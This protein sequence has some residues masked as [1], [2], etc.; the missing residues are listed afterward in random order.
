MKSYRFVLFAVG[1]IIFL[2]LSLSAQ[3]G[4]EDKGKGKKGPPFELG[5]VLP[6]FIRDEL[7]LTD[8]QQK[9]IAELEKL[10]RAKLLKILTEEQQKRIQGMAGK[11]PKGPEGKD[12]G[13]KAP[14][15]EKDKENP[16]ERPALSTDPPTANLVKNPVFARGSARP[17]VPDHYTLE[18]DVEWVPA[19]GKYEFAHR[20]IALHSGKDLNRDGSRSGSVSQDVIAFTPGRGKWFRFSCRG[21]AES[22]FAVEKD[23]L[24]M[25][26]DYFSK[27]GPL[28]G[29]TRK[30]YPQIEKDRIDLAENGKR[31]Q[32]GGS[33]WKTYQH[34]FMLPF[35][36]IDR[37]RLTVVFR[38]GAAVTDKQA[39]FFVS[40]FSLI[41]IPDP[42]ER[43]RPVQSAKGKLVAPDDL[44]SL[45]GRW[46]YRPEKPGDKTVPANLVIDHR[47]A[48]QLFYLDHQLSNPF[49]EN[50]SSWLLK[51]YL[52][53][54]GN[55]VAQD[56]FVPD[57]IVIRFE[58]KTMI[59]QTK[60]L[61]NHPTAV[62]PALAGSGDRNPNYI[63]EQS[64]TFYLPLEPKHNPNAKA[65]DKTNSNRALPMGPIG[66]ALNGVVFFN[67]F[68]ADIQD[69]TDLMDRCCGHP[70]P[71]NQY[72]Y[73]KYPVCV[74]SPFIDE[75]NDHS[76]LIGFALDGF[77]VYGPYE[78]KG[79]MAKDA[80]DQ[81]LNDFNVH[82]DDVH[83]WH[84][85]VTP[86]RY[87]Y[88]IGGYWG[89][90][91]ARNGLKKGGK[92]K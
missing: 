71:R 10:V 74:K 53:R 76:P 35:A 6:P 15:E 73:H 45:G 4:G 86:G 63:Q 72:H 90:V 40:E 46:Y 62:F 12:K 30:L 60:N 38:H 21:L 68:D 8:D 39:Q 49:A 92:K 59:V 5:K 77:P 29:V 47:N 2:S 79:Q 83:G 33:V 56:R 7:D 81:P 11:G 80:R 36:E 34:D 70:S 28:D 19:G 48:D 75:G 37:L 20:G 22:N 9:Q 26:V 85:H 67:P 23:G 42:T 89:E 87:P 41:P 31:R 32:G 91:D 16:A 82:H 66:I 58:G 17:G 44:V 84:Y 13:P 3:P 88:I 52:D 25:K 55:L 18:G 61:P 1:L 57:N 43:S 69:A 51:G 78:G 50:M 27:T 64:Q 14:P 24:L 65:M 54:Q